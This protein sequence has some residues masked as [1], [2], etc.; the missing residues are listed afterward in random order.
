MPLPD[1]FA[2][3]AG[4]RTFEDAGA[5]GANVD[6]PFLGIFAVEKGSLRYFR[7]L[8]IWALQELHFSLVNVAKSCGAQ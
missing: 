8:L 3:N 5:E 7:L 4:G 6:R 1:G 2:E